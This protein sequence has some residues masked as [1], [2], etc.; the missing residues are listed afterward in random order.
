[1]R[2]RRRAWKIRP[3]T[4]TSARGS[5]V[6][7]RKDAE[8]RSNHRGHRLRIDCARSAHTDEA[9]RKYKSCMRALERFPLLPRWTPR[10][11]DAGN[12]GE[13]PLLSHDRGVIGVVGR[14]C[15]P[16]GE[17]TSDEHERSLS[18]PGRSRVHRS[19][20][21]HAPQARRRPLR[22]ASR[23]R[24]VAVVSLSVGQNALSATVTLA[25]RFYVQQENPL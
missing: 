10:R 12:A 14:G 24:G 6:L 23:R 11:W 21:H 19:P 15:G 4:R 22:S 20:S 17:K 9:R 1:M 7:H 25:G 13:E 16:R 3:R 18:G 2:S 8:T 5:Q